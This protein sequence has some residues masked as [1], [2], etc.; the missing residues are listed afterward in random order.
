MSNN[1]AKPDIK[2]NNN[3]KSLFTKKSDAGKGDYPRNISRNY[4]NN[5][6]LIKGFK[7]SKYP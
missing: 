7:K 2:P 1:N 6:E 4:W 3:D 5:W